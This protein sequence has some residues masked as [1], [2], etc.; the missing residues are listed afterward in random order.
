MS[1]VEKLLIQGKA[2]GFTRIPN[3]IV[4]SPDL[5]PDQ[6]A[7]LAVI[8]SY[9]FADR[10]FPKHQKIAECI[11]KSRSSVKRY[12]NE[13][14]EKGFITWKKTLYGRT[15]QYYINETIGELIGAESKSG[16]EPGS[17]PEL[18]YQP[19][20]GRANEYIT[21]SNNEYLKPYISEK[22][23]QE[24]IRL[25]KKGASLVEEHYKRKGMPLPERLKKLPDEVNDD[26]IEMPF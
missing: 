9:S 25:L 6:K 14:R 4:R 1:V 15:N 3:F 10:C 18:N 22:S 21:N 5:S 26:E 13:L 11:G 23:P 8:I 2:G 19:A 7:V 20:Q 12:L 17:G 16:G 24:R